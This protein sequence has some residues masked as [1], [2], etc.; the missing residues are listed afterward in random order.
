MADAVRD[1]HAIR[2]EEKSDGSPSA[3]PT[4]TAPTRDYDGCVHDEN[5]KR[6]FAFPRMVEDLL[7]GFVVGEWIAGVDF[8][9]LQKL[10]A[11][12]IGDERRRRHGDTVWRIRHRE[13]WLH[14]L[15]LLEFQSSADPDM[16]LRILEYTTLLHRELGRNEA[17]GPDGKRPAVLPVVLYNG[18]APWMAAVEVRELITAVG[19]S[20]APYQ[21]SQRYLVLDERRME[22]DDL[23]SHNLVTAVVRLEQSRS[24][25]DLV[26]VVEAL[27]RWHRSPRDDELMRVFV[28]WVLRLTERFIPN[29]EEALP[30]VRTLEGVKMTL[31]ERV[32]QWPAQW[33]REGMEQGRE[34]GLAQGLEQGLEH[35]RALL[36]RMAASRFGK[37]T[38]ERLSGTLARIGDPERLADI[39]DWLVRCDTEEEFLHRA[40]SAPDKVEPRSG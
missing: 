19:P 8:S 13:G 5:Y 29:E 40:G 6:L 17:L 2:F 22:D 36:C 37:I 24:P 27:R 14:V 26:R 12:Y 9:T 39:G 21:P 30:P 25:A 20:L 15:V 33:M 1:A 3:G 23:P 34:Q 7:R 16:A 38:A 18:E 35:E 32:S 31:E 11:E 28:D 10:S 4:R